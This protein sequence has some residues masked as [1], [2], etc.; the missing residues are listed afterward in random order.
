MF[1]FEVIERERKEWTKIIRCSMQIHAKDTYVF[2]CIHCSFYAEV[3]P[4]EILAKDKLELIRCVCWPRA[5]PS[6]DIIFFTEVF[7]D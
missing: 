2:R 6:I 5:Q 3:I 7:I 1:L 4:Q